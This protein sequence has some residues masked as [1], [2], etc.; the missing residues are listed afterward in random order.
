M[1][2]SHVMK[3]LS[4]RAP[5]SLDEVIKVQM[6]VRLEQSKKGTCHFP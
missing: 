3:I 6:M 4:M 1:G 2:K 5:F